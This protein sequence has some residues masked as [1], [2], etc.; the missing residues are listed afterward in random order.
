MN[1]SYKNSKNWTQKFHIDEKTEVKKGNS[2]LNDK[3]ERSNHGTA[4][5]PAQPK[6][7]LAYDKEL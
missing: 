3:C 6:Q 5:S 7:T 4:K 1:K 2:R